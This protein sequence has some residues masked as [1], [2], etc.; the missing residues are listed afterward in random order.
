MV[1][2]IKL[3]SVNQV[4]FISKYGCAIGTWKDEI[5]PE[6]KVYNVEIDIVQ[7]IKYND[8]RVGDSNEPRIESVLGGILISGLL[9]EYDVDGCA[10]LRLGDTLIEVET[11]FDANFSYICGQYISFMVSKIDIYDE[12]IL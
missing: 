4:S 7:L 9:I 5:A 12:H 3:I 11:E 1:I 6:E 8:I 10:T 2:E